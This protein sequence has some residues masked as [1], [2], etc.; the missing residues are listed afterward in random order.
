MD[1]DMQ[2]VRVPRL[3]GRA[4]G[5][6]VRMAESR[7]TRPLI[8]G[9]LLASAG[10]HGF[11]AAQLGEP[12]S[13]VPSLPRPG[14]SAGKASAGA[15]SGGHTLVGDLQSLAESA[16]VGPGFR[17]ESIADFA[18]AYRE[19]TSDPVAVAE[20]ALAAIDGADQAEPPLRAMIA[21]RPDDVRAQAHAAAR[22]HRSGQPLGPLD[23]V[24]VAVKDEFHMRGYPT[25]AGTRFL[26]QTAHADATVVARLRDA[27]A[28][29]IS[30][31]NMHEIGIDTTGFNPHHGTPVNPYGPGRYP[32]GSS[33]GSA[34]AVAAGLCPVA[35]AADGGGSIRVPAALCGVVGLKPT[36]SRVS[37]A[38]AFPLCWSVAH[39]GP[40]A[41]TARDAAIAYALMA[42]PDPLDPNTL[43]QP[44][45]DLD[46]LGTAGIDGLRLGIFSEWFE[47]AEPDV[48]GTCQALIAKLE[49]LGARVVP[50]T[51][52]DLELAR[53]AHGVTILS[54]MVAAMEPYRDR[55]RE[56]S[57][58]V[59][60]NLAI[61]RELTASDYVRAQQVRTRLCAAMEEAF[62]HTDVIVTPTTGL[63]APRIAAAVEPLGESNLELTSALMRFIFPANLSGHPAISFPAGYDDAGLPIGLQCI[64]RPWQESTLLRVAEAAEQLVQRRPPRISSRLL[65]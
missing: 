20:R 22:R 52:P 49:D 57:L 32:G 31:A 1:Y 40:V 65:D 19:R 62:Q 42:G 13:P 9:R 59:R 33:S 48:V 6:F 47:H 41:A 15:G 21:V 39:P 30:K 11:R 29:L 35:V 12:P 61:A 2:T 14:T 38:G 56:L 4:L 64:G 51:I 16:P 8:I 24:P 37:D 53:V 7:A 5:L 45:P 25:T 10:L 44:A 3:A 28:V 63:V 23:G 46:G 43:G 18:R 34:V 55:W 54:E 26:R 58:P 36:W 27:G 17:F 60:L 50:L